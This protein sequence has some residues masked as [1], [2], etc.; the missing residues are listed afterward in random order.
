MNVPF[1]IPSPN[2]QNQSQVG[3]F[4][5]LLGSSSDSSDSS[6]LRKAKLAAFDIWQKRLRE[7][8]NEDKFKEKP[9]KGWWKKPTSE[10]LEKIYENNNNKLND[11]INNTIKEIK[12][13]S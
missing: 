2:I 9:P 4:Q 13:K 6:S 12:L 1:M 8:F 5:S 11:S 7:A 3:S 10:E